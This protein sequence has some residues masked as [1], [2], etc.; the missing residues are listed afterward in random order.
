MKKYL[1]TIKK[2]CDIVE[3]PFYNEF[4]IELKRYAEIRA[5]KQIYVPGLDEKDCS[6]CMECYAICKS[7]NNANVLSR[8]GFLKAIA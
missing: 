4:C 2:V 7:K 3:S 6:K 8:C 1:E 5:E